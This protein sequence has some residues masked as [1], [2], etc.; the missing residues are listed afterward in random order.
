VVVRIDHIDGLRG[1][2]IGSV[3]LF[4]AFARWPDLVPYGSRYADYFGYGWLGVEL[5]FL[6]SGFVILMTLERSRSFGDFM[7]RRWLRLF[8]AMLICSAII[9]LTAPAFP[10]RPTGAPRLADIVP[11]ITFIDN[12][13]LEL[14]GG[15][16]RTL[17]GSFW[18]LF[19]EMKF[20]IGFGLA[21]FLAGR[22][23]AIAGLVLIFILYP[24]TQALGLGAAHYALYLLDA[25]YMA[26][27]ASGALFY[28]STKAGDWRLM[29]AAIAVGVL[30]AFGELPGQG[31][32]PLPALIVVGLF[33]I[34]LTVPTVQRTLTTPPIMF[35]GA[36][37]YPLYLLHEGAM[38]STVR[39]LGN[40][41]LPGFLLPFIPL[42]GL[43]VLAW[44]IAE[45][46]EGPARGLLK[47]RLLGT[48]RWLP[49]T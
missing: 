47:R 35:L 3:A 46:I 45:H 32:V 24:L 28:L 43:C 27:F 8:P 40:A 49:V 25:P 18:S 5:F 31:V 41:P 4:H 44:L 1:V 38:I 6:I 29:A 33:T 20:Y 16:N 30:A 36:I 19:V 37:S 7:I 9:F 13:W 12:R 14:I 17:E 11:G 21:Y 48:R 10:Y 2:A 26:W 23:F 22:T 42:A 15:P 34:V 39:W